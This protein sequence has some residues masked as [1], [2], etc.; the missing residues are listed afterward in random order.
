MGL[1]VN[2]WSH[3]YAYEHHFHSLFDD[4]YDDPDDPRY[5]HV[6]ARKRFGRIAIVNSDAGALAMVEG[7]VEQAHR[8][9]TE[10]LKI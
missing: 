1:T 9:V 5:P 10:L 7:A 3:G 6:K 2:R 8:A 4:D